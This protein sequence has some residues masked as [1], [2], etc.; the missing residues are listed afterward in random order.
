[1]ESVYI[2]GVNASGVI[3]PQ[4][5]LK[6]KVLGL[7]ITAPFGSA[8]DVTVNISGSVTGLRSFHN[9]F[10]GELAF[11]PNERVN[12]TTNAFTANHSAVVNYILVGDQQMFMELDKS[13]NF[14]YI[15]TRLK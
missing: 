2:S 13:R 10:N 8:T 12:I 4:P 1:M 9:S 5:A 11:G 6:A 15:P 7:S 3:L 14:G